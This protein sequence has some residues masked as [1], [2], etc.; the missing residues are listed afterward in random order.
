MWATSGS[1]SLI[2]DIRPGDERRSPEVGMAVGKALRRL[3]EDR[4]RHTLRTNRLTGG[5]KKK[6]KNS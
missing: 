3:E 6:L 2:D 1:E 4:F 5:R